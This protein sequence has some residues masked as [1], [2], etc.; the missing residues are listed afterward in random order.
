M[1]PNF[2][3]VAA[4]WPKRLPFVGFTGTGRYSYIAA[5][6]SEVDFE[7]F[8]TLPLPSRPDLAAASRTPFV[9]GWMGVLSYDD[10][11]RHAL[12]NAYP[13]SLAATASR[14]FRVTRLLVY[15]ALERIWWLS[16]R[17]ESDEQSQYVL[18]SEEIT[19]LLSP[20]EQLRLP[21]LTGIPLVG[22]LTGEA[23]RALATAAI[24]Q[25]REGRFYQINLLRYFQLQREPDQAWLL[26]RLTRLAEAFACYIDVPGLT[27][28]S[29]SPERFM[30]LTPWTDTTLLAMAEPIKGTAPRAHD[31]HAFDRQMAEH[32]LSSQKDCAELHMIVDLLR[33][34]LNRIAQRGS[35]QVIEASRLTAHSHVYHLSAQI[36][37]LI[38]AGLSIGDFL[39]A[40]C[41]AGSITGAPKREVMLAIAETENRARGFFMGHA[42]YLDR[43]GRFD[44]SVLIRTL[45][46]TAEHFEYAAGSG[47]T[48]HSDPRSEEREIM[49][50]SQV[51]EADA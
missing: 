8:K 10:L 46:R 32:L 44:S 7:T 4:R 20:V 15:D 9:A 35:V 18:T 33:N 36:Q 42:F 11:A 40:L 22:Q 47:L 49:A 13:Q 43:S 25:I 17:A 27:L 6:F 30:Q 21:D 41:P 39:Q 29:F 19:T 37:A 2:S 14:I 23:Y 3:Q 34:D 16:D 28:A 45:V 5:A 12:G 50:K 38:A 48:I 26:A 51:V 31:N 24:E 1:V